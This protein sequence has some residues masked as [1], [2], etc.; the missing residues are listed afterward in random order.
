MDV[1]VSPF[2]GPMQHESKLVAVWVSDIRWLHPKEKKLETS[3]T[4]K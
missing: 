4:I 2:N 1:S 3:Q